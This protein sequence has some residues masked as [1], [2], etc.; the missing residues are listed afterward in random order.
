MKLGGHIQSGKVSFMGYDDFDGRPVPDLL[1]RIKVCMWEREVDFFDY[2]GEFVPTPLL[3]K[4]LFINESFDYFNEQSDFD[5][6]LMRTQLFDFTRDIV[7]KAQFYGTLERAGYRITGYELA[8]V[9]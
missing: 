7:S 5:Q 2:I 9:T 3:M 4:S 6:S 1:E 8:Q